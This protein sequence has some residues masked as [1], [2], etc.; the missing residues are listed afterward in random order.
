MKPFSCF[1]LHRAGRLEQLDHL[2]KNQKKI[3]K[4]NRIKEKRKGFH[5]YSFL[6]N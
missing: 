1:I 4:K 2:K 6:Q 5:N 3:N